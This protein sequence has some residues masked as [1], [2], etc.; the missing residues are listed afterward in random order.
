MIWS[1]LVTSVL[2]VIS[3]FIF[4]KFSNLTSTSTSGGKKAFEIE[5]QLLSA[6][7][8]NRLDDFARIFKEHQFPANYVT[9][10]KKSLLQLCVSYKE[11]GLPFMHYLIDQGA[12]VNF[13]LDVR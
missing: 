4:K 2:I 5:K 3:M 9:V 8:N 7:A 6:L 11:H 12:D 13:I 10:M 1:I